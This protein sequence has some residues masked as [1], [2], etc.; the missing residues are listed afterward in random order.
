MSISIYDGANTAH[1][2]LADC[3]HVLKP[4]MYKCFLF[5]CFLNVTALDT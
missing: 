4:D 2:A 5:F 3:V 1:P